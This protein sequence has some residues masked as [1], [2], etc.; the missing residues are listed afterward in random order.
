MS[1]PTVAAGHDRDPAAELHLVTPVIVTYNSAHC[2]PAIADCLRPYRSV[3][4]SDNS[5]DDDTLARAK[6][7]IPQAT[8]LAHPRNLGFGTANNRALARVSTPY[9]LLLNPDCAIAP[10][11]VAHL[12]ATALRFPDAAIIGPQVLDGAGRPEINYRWASTRWT[13]R[14]PAASGPACVGFLSGA[15]MLLSMDVC[16]PLGFFDE[17]F[18]LYYEDD[19]LCLKYFENRHSL[20]IDPQAQATH[21]ARRSVKGRAPLRGEFWRGYHHAQSKMTYTAKHVGLQKAY[22]LR[23]RLIWQTAVG[24]PLRVL[25]FSPRMIARTFG[26]LVGAREWTHQQK[27]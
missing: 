13:S 7:L 5:S 25:A 2:I 19:D 8:I 20:I 11:D 27:P 16:A 10:A 21:L 26:R 24:L 17:R 22:R 12:V 4:I 9:A 1:D 23:T 18:F 3:L 14:G 6:A 15:A